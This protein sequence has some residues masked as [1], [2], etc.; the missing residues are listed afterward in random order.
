VVHIVDNAQAGA[1]YGQFA[2]NLF[3]VKNTREGA[4]GLAELGRAAVE[5]MLELGM[6]VDLAHASDKTSEEVLSLAEAK[7]MPLINS[8]GG[9]RALL[10]I[11]RNIPDTFAAR[12]AKLGGTVGVTL[13]DHMVAAVADSERWEG[14]VPGT[15]D[16]VIA[17]WKHLG[18]VT[19]YDALTLGSDFNGLIARPRA[20]GS[21]PHGIRNAGDLNEL[22]EALVAHGV[23][24]D[25]LDNM[26]ERF[27]QMWDAL[28][29]RASPAARAEAQ[30][31]STE[32]G[33]VFDVAL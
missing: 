12:I 5:R 19:G 21:C 17:H 33:H 23:P 8:H 29:A 3:H 2:Y 1:S 9:A 11:E 30:G 7:R 10:P 20:G 16:D 14:Y 32:A 28:E 4:R 27:L 6:M 22:Y 18:G 13:F 24:K 25:S 31:A 15:C 26:G